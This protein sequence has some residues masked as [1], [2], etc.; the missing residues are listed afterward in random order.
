MKME[1]SVQL[2]L[3]TGI[4]LMSYPLLQPQLQIW[5]LQ[6]HLS[7]FV[8]FL[9]DGV[10]YLLLLSYLLIYSFDNP[11]VVNSILDLLHYYSILIC[12]ML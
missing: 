1:L 2:V 9:R 7:G 12:S 3:F 11:F 10:A 8:R 4:Y 5:S 6:I